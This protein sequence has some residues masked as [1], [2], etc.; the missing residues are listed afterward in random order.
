MDFLKV[1]WN[2]LRQGPVTEAFPFAEAPTPARFRGRVVVDPA[3]CVGCGTCE[4]VCAGGAI[5]ISRD[6][7]AA[8]GGEA[9]TSEH[10]AK[11][12]EPGFT[13]TVWHNTCCLCAQC[14][15]YC[16]TRAITLST[17]WHNAHRADRKYTF[18]EQV[19]ISYDTCTACGARLRLLPASVIA[20][21]YEG[22]PEI[23]VERVSRL[24]PDCRQ[25]ETAI[26]DDRACRISHLDDLVS[27]EQACRITHLEDLAAADQACLLPPAAPKE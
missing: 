25:I 2:N 21:I 4:H 16:P 7:T 9:E 1:L 17:N 3:L 18:V 15:H 10:G 27:A 22:H 24:C 20:R 19:S 11:R 8:E 26:A 13:I 14:R 23:D 6:A 12:G 5:H